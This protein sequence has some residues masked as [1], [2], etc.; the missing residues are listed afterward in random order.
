MASKHP[1]NDASI[2]PQ[3]GKRRQN[4]VLV[5]GFGLIALVTGHSG[6]SGGGAC[7]SGACMI[8][9][10]TRVDGLALGKTDR[11]TELDRDF[12]LDGSGTGDGK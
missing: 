3:P 9:E 2:S 5:A 6:R 4:L 1:N 7:L 11:P 12:D 10:F 8:P